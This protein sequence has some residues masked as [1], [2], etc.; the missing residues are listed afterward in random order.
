[1]FDFGLAPGRYPSE[2]QQERIVQRVRPRGNTEAAEYKEAAERQAAEYAK[3]ERMQVERIG[4]RAD[5]VKCR[6]DKG[7]DD[8]RE[9]TRRSC[10]DAQQRARRRGKTRHEQ[11]TEEQFP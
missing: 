3:S 10:A 11:D 1:V 6:K 2:Q 7:A 9:H 4:K 5:V 8:N